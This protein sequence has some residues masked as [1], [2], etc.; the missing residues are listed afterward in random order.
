MEGSRR[1]LELVK[2][3]Q[4]IFDAMKG[5]MTK[6]TTSHS[7]SKRSQGVLRPGAVPFRGG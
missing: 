1:Q 6:G 2:A 7:L 5:A 3:E 4:S